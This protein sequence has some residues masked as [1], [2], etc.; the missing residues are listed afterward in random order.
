[1]IEKV[2]LQMTDDGR[3]FLSADGTPCDEINPKAMMLFAGAKCAGFTVLMIMKQSR[4]TAKHLEISVSGELT[5][6]TL[7]AESEFRSFHYVYNIECDN[8]ADQIKLR[9]AADLA[10]TK[11]CGL[12]RMFEKIAPVTHEIAV[13]ATKP[14][15]AW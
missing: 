12:A 5:T 1:M 3:N 4:V 2:T 13:V 8:E 14:V 7:K 6:D 9:N 11:Y 10:H 15:K